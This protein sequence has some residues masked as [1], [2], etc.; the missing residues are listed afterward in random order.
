MLCCNVLH[1]VFRKQAVLPTMAGMVTMWARQAKKLLLPYALDQH[2]L[3]IPCNLCQTDQNRN[4]SH[5]GLLVLS[6][7]QVCVVVVLF[8]QLQATWPEQIC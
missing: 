4:G 7:V 3:L 6:K 1:A 2:V 8:E 5:W